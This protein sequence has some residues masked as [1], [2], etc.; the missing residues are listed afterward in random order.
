MLV[1]DCRVEDLAFERAYS[2]YHSP[3]DFLT[4]MVFKRTQAE[5]LSCQC[6]IRFT[7]SELEDLKAAAHIAGITV[8]TYVRHRALGRQVAANTDLVTIRELRRIGGL[9]KH[10]HNESG[11]AY[12]QLTADTLIEIQKAIVNIG[13]GY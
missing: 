3:A 6:N 4:F 5:P 12:S 10:I 11:G 9:L 13:N 8:S 1:K 2:N 7:P